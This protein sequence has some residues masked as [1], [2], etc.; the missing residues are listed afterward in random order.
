LFLTPKPD[1]SGTVPPPG[2]PVFKGVPRIALPLFALEARNHIPQGL[3]CG[4]NAF[5]A[6][7]PSGSAQVGPSSP[8]PPSTITFPSGWRKFPRG[9]RIP[10]PIVSGRNPQRPGC[11]PCQPFLRTKHM[12]LLKTGLEMAHSTL[13]VFWRGP[14]LRARAKFWPPFAP[15]ENV[16][17]FRA[18]LVPGARGPLWGSPPSAPFADP[19]PLFTAPCQPTKFPTPNRVRP[20]GACLVK[21]RAAPL[22]LDPVFPQC[23]RSKSNLWKCK[24]GNRLGGFTVLRPPAAVAVPPP[25]PPAPCLSSRHPDSTVPRPPNAPMRPP[26]LLAL[27]A[28]LGLGAGC[29][30]PRWSTA[31]PT[32]PGHWLG[33][34][35]TGP[36]PGCG[37][38]PDRLPFGT[39]TFFFL[40]ALKF[41][42]PLA[43]R[44]VPPCFPAPISSVPT[45][46]GFV[47]PP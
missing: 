7:R 40:F 2:G 45:P 41:S 31:L 25:P 10:P 5:G 3:R 47:P 38:P 15:C 23:R 11:P 1:K 21:T 9:G 14:K 39:P 46:R 13:G 30:V 32:V 12:A 34:F 24:M 33:V 28:P 17:C 8:P 27:P 43:P 22:G 6:P 4:K 35:L 16:G 18:L 42:T 19:P 44:F 29:S 36:H 37:L 20:Q 26:F